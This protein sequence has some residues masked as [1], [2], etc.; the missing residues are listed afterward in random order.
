MV[1]LETG[2]ALDGRATVAGCLVSVEG[3]GLRFTR[4]ANAVKMLATMTDQRWDNKWKLDGPHDPDLKIRMLGDAIKDCP[5]WRETGLPRTSLMATPAIWQGETL[6]SAPVAGLL[7][8]WTA[9][10]VA[11]F[12]SS[13]VTH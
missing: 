1:H 6:I 12:H 13:L 5:N 10:I 9:R 2:L 8:G 11:D 4:E 3:G 7:N